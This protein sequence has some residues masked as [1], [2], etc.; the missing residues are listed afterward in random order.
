MTTR[1]VVTHSGGAS[2][3]LQPNGLY[4]G[5]ISVLYSSASAS[6]KVQ[7]LGDIVIGPCRALSGLSLSVG[8]QVLC[9]YVNGQTDEMIILGVIA[10]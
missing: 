5:V 7:A 6:V 10:S 2:H 1:N 8:K 3:P 9:S 4:V